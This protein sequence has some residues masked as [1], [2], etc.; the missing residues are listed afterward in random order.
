M[1]RTVLV[2]ADYARFFASVLS[3]GAVAELFA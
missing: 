2:V 1:S 3:G